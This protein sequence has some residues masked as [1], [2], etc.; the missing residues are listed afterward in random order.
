MANTRPLTAAEKNLWRKFEI[1]TEIIAA[2]VERCLHSKKQCAICAAFGNQNNIA[3]PSVDAENKILEK[4]ERDVVKLARIRQGIQF[5]A[6]GLSFPQG[7]S[8]GDF[9]MVADPTANEDELAYYQMSGVV[10]VVVGLVII[11]SAI[12]W[13]IWER[14]QT[15]K[16]IDRH[17][18]VKSVAQAKFCADPNSDICARWLSFRQAQGYNDEQT[19]VDD[20]YDRVV[21]LQ[22]AI[23]GAVS[24]GVSWAIPLI[25]LLGAFVLLRETR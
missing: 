6:I 12:T 17:E 1:Y 8:S 23:P 19:F 5:E 20:L 21:E 2:E 3:L 7:A 25:A 16:V 4:L 9:D 13:A 15:R 14:G 22:D 18:A 10:F 24:T 11:G